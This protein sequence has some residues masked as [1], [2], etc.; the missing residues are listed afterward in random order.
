M[1][2]RPNTAVLRALVG[3]A[4][5]LGGV[6]AAGV[7]T[8]GAVT[9]SVARRVILPPGRRPDDTPLLHVD[10]DAGVVR[11]GVSDDALLAGTYSFWFDGGAG[12]LRVGRILERGIGWVD[13]EL[14]GVDAGD[15]ATADRGRFNGWVYLTPAALGVP[16]TEER[17]QTTLGLAPAW[18]VPA[19]EDTGRWVVLVHGRAT[20]RQEVLRAVPVFRAAG[21][22]SLLVSYRT[23]GEAPPTPD[24]RYALG[25]TEWL[26]VESAILHAL[27]RGA[28]E[29]V[30]MG[31]SMGGAIVLQT[32]TRSRVASVVTGIVL[33]SPVV[34][35]TETLMHHGQIMS[36][37]S[38]VKRGVLSM[39]SS[40]WG[41]WLTGQDEPI[42]LRRLDFVARA[43]ELTV[44]ILLLHSE[45]DTYAPAASS[46]RLAAARPDLVRYVGFRT[47]HHTRLWNFDRE[48]WDRSIG[49]WLRGDADAVPAAQPPKSNRE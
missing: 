40:G 42:D 4:A 28:T 18:C 19:E 38:P 39:L 24:K 48:R 17:V 2:Q 13:R 7:V 31:W 11:F 16:F 44:P 3:G 25:D 10:V 30:L 45:D 46:K 35:W 49:A 41:G 27:D 47:A 43:R 9:A 36:L 5:A 37:P 23:D 12:H 32:V 14:L 21:Y 26:D 1:P 22:T 34:S 20:V 33:D 15:P 29:V 8:T 6:V